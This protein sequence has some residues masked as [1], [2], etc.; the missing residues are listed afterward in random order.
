MHP[1]LERLFWRSPQGQ[2]IKAQALADAERQEKSLVEQVRAAESAREAEVA[3]LEQ[4][5]QAVGAR[6]AE[7]R[8]LLADLAA[9]EVRLNQRHVAGIPGEVERA[10]RQYEAACAPLRQA[11]QELDQVKQQLP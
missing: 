9:E 6:L 5:R 10:W 8:R 7:V 4:E 3:G 2:E 11:L 1:V